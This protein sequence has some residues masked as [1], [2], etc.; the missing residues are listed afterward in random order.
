MLNMIIFYLKSALTEH[1]VQAVRT[2][3]GVKMALSV[4]TSGE[5]ALVNQGGG[6]RSVKSPVLLGK[7]TKIALSSAS[8]MYI[9]TH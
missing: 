3:V 6:E 8:M 4:T 9:I 2:D 7:C 5:H 1:T